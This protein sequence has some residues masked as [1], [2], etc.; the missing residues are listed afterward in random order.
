M[1]NSEKVIEWV[2]KESGLK[3]QEDWEKMDNFLE[4]GML[5]SIK[6]MRLLV[7]IEEILEKELEDDEI[8]YA[9][10][11]SIDSIESWYFK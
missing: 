6:L 10:L 11:V 9:H 1:S 3:Y 5:D 4:S 2:E 7:F 8:S